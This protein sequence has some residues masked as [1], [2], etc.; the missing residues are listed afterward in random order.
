MAGTRTWFGKLPAETGIVGVLLLLCIAFSI[1]TVA[2]E[3]PEGA[4]AGEALAKQVIRDRPPEPILIVAGT[5]RD[6]REF[7]EVF[8]ARLKS[9][10]IP[11]GGTVVGTPADAKDAFDSSAVRTVVASRTA[12]RWTLWEKQ[13]LVTPI[14]PQSRVWPRFLTADNLLNVANQVAVIAILAAGM[15]LVLITGHVDLSVGSLI[16]LSAVLATLWIRKY[17]GAEGASTVGMIACCG[18]AVLV[19]GLIGAA[20]GLV[21]TRFAVP[22]F[23]IT[24]GVMKM[25]RGGAFKASDGE[26][27]YQLPDAF[28][29]LG[30]GADLFGIPN[31]VVLMAL[32]YVAVHLIL[33]RT[34]FG[35]YVY[36]VGGNAEAA[37]LAG[38]RVSAV[39]VLVFVLNGLFAGLGGVVLA[40]QLKSGSPT[41]GVEYEL[42]VIAGVV[43]GGTSL[44]GGQGNVLGTLLGAFLL[45]VIQN[46][47]NLTGVGSYDQQVVLGG[48]IVL[49]VLLDRLKAKNR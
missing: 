9:A 23:I 21:V 42:F 5:G 35:R 33:T 48:I 27:V 1:A 11:V 22:S 44:S 4:A 39:V 2:E 24:L 3:R 37:R 6:D 31:A 10:G 38:V 49:A 14:S 30:R 34:T 13:K 32:I 17:A 29:W 47:M 25:A 26:S 43:V 46:G 18:A 7:A 8:E 28:V 45:A 20:S 16:A 36:A 41:F 15:T 40:S 12:A 19:C